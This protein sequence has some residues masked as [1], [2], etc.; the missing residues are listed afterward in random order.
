MTAGATRILMTVDAIG[1]VWTYAIDLAAALAPLGF[2]CVLALLG[3]PPT[4]EQRRAV[5]G[6]AGARLLT[7]DVALDWL[8]PD[9]STVVRGGAAIAAIA[10]AER[11]DLVHLNQPALAASVRFPGPVVVAAHSCVATWW[12]A[13]GTGG[14][15][16]PDLAWQTELFTAG[17]R[18]ADAIVCPSA[19]HAEAVRRRYDLTATPA[20]VHNGR[21]ALPIASAAM[22]DFAF[23]AGRLWDGGKDIAT[24]DR[25]AQ[26]LGIPFKAAGPIAAPGGAA[27]PV[28]HLHLLGTLGVAAL[29][30]CLAARPVFISAARYEPFGLAVLEAALAGCALVLSDIPTFR[31]LWDGA[32][33]FVPAGDDAGFAAAI[34]AIVGDVPSRL[35]RGDLARR[36]AAQFSPRRMAAATAAIYRKLLPGDAGHGRRAA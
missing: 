7:T 5:A 22:H 9:S 26:R 36:R 6:I 35:V 15:L 20:V 27:I 11:A 14:R 19:A 4:A 17:L 18:A 16:P 34:E 24:L 21:S 8:A 10:R 28:E 2:D 3:P 1:G 29:A 31:E 13:A 25:A 23:T 33:T 30:D 12:D 32:A